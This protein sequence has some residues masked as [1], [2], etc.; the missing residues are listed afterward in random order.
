MLKAISA[1]DYLIRPFLTHKQQSYFITSGAGS[2]PAQIS[3]D[4]ATMPPSNWL[5]ATTDPVNADGIYQYELYNSLVQ[6]FYTS[7]SALS[8]SVSGS[9]SGNLAM[10]WGAG[11]DAA[12]L[13]PLSNS[14]WVISMAQSSWGEGIRPS[15]FIVSTP[16]YSSSIMDD[17]NGRLYDVTYINVNLIENSEF[18]KDSGG[19]FSN[20]SAINRVSTVANN[21]T[22]SMQ[23]ND[24]KRC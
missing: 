12:R 1:D 9:A 21:G 16:L 15:S 14:A 24:D 17:G 7:A 18:E 13:L 6:L 4:L 20:A 22:A 19:A 23:N 11:G 8:G 10:N 5:F 3:V 2:N